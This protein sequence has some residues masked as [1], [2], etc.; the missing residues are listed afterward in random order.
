MSSSYFIKDDSTKSENLISY[1]QSKGLDREYI[2]QIKQ[3]RR[4]MK[5]R[6]YAA[7]CR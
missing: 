5:N 6:G 2:K 1:F 3:Q 7:S 4:T